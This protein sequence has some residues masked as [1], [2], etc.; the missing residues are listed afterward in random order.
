MRKCIE[1]GADVTKPILDYGTATVARS[2][3]CDEREDGG[4]TITVPA[5]RRGSFRSIMTWT[6]EPFML[7]LIPFIWLIYKFS[8]T[9]PPRAILRLTPAEFAV[10]ETS[11]EGLG[12]FPA[13]RMWPRRDVA[14]LR[15]NRYGPGL[16][17]RIP[18]RESAD[19]LTDLSVD[20]IVQIS[21]ALAAARQRLDF[22]E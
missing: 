13:C 6:S 2:I 18:G 14:E 3:S 17:L 12:L 16:F 9:R 8:S 11:D 7:P 22:H 15:P 10:T 21:D 20:Q 5:F 19:L 1:G 4:V